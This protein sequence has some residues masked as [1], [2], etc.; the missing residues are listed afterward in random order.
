MTSRKL[1]KQIGLLDDV[2]IR[3]T[4]DIR[5]LTFKKTE[6]KDKTENKERH[7]EEFTITVKDID[8]VK[9]IIE[10]WK[11]RYKFDE[12]AFENYSFDGKS[13][14]VRHVQKMA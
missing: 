1:L 11:E 13:T 4:D 12:L 9:D 6:V 14:R 8:V 7:V 5:Y 2:K 3:K 10:S